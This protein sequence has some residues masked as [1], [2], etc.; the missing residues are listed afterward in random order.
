MNSTKKTS[1]HT[2]LPLNRSGLVTKAI[3]TVLRC[4]KKIADKTVF[5]L[6]SDVGAI[7]CKQY[8]K[9]VALGC[10]Y[11]GYYFRYQ[12]LIDCDRTD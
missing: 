4:L 6:N 5:P 10:C 11:L 8:N 9:N 3:I 12:P 2:K 1:K 7:R